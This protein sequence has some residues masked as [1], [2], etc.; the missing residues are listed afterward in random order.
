MLIE[1]RRQTGRRQ[2]M[3]A[4]CGGTF[5][6]WA[7]ASAHAA[8][9]VVVP[10]TQEPRHHVRFENEYVRI[11]EAI[12]VPGDQSLF[13]KHAL[14][15]VNITGPQQTKVRVEKLN[16]P[17]AAVFE[18]S[19][20]DTFYAGW[21][22]NPLIHRVAN[23]DAA[24]TAVYFDCEINVPKP[25]QFPA[26]D[27]KAVPAYASMVDN[28]RAQ[29]WRLKLAP[30]E[31]APPVTQSGP[32][33]RVVVAGNQLR[34]MVQGSPDRDLFVFPGH[35]EYQPAG[36]TRAITNTGSAPLELVEFEIK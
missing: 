34:E 8:E 18:D 23:I 2:F 3:C 19:P 13:H 26:P 6:G 7:L 35:Y 20:G 32:G 30:G 22:D 15:S 11:I 28:A 16:D 12:F 24:R 17:K 33:V 1:P 10:V 25:G 36:R 14:D 29:A 27:R 4:C 5:V 9:V 31:S 21:H